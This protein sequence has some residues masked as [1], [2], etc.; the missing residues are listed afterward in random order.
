MFELAK[1][2][3]V[4]LV[5]V[6]VPVACVLALTEQLGFHEAIASPDDRPRAAFEDVSGRLFRRITPTVLPVEAIDQKDRELLLGTIE[7]FR[8][9]NV[10]EGKQHIVFL[11]RHR[12]A[13]LGAGL[14][15]DD[16]A[17]QR[18]DS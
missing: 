17:I 7:Q 11:K 2:F 3:P 15:A 18:V 1:G 8:H 10:L 6:A 13:L 5:A 14:Q 16:S 12:P 9:R 4:R